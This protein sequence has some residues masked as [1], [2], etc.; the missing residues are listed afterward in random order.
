MRTHC[1]NDYHHWSSSQLRNVNTRLEDVRLS[2]KDK[3]AMRKSSKNRPLAL[4][5]GYFCF[6]ASAH[7]SFLT[8][9]T[10]MAE[11]WEL[12]GRGGEWGGNVLE[13]AVYLQNVCKLDEWSTHPQGR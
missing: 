10:V 6:Q 1:P 4:G 5:P 9:G 12:V 3:Q 7:S 2:L 11:F 13:R 8:S